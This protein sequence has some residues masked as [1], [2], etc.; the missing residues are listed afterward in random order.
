M[1][2][3]NM[4]FITLLIFVL[5]S[6]NCLNAKPEINTVSGYRTEVLENGLNVFVKE[7]PSAPVVAINVWTHVGSRNEGQGEEGYSH[8]IE[9]LLFKGTKTRGVGD[10]DKEIKKLGATNNAFTATD[11]TCLH[12]FGAK[13]HFEKLLELQIDAAFNSVFDETEFTKELQVVLEELRMDNDD[14]ESR[15]YHETQKSAY[16]NHSYRNPVI[17]YKESLEGATREKVF[18]YY[19]KFYVPGN[20]WIVVVGDVKTEQVIEKVRAL[21]STIAS[22]PIPDQIIKG[23]TPQEKRRES[24][25][26]GDIQQVYLNLAWHAPGISNPDNFAMDVISIMMGRGRSSRLYK[27]LVEVEGLASDLRAVY[28]TS[29]DPSLFYVSA[30]CKPSMKLQL[31]ERVLEMFEELKNDPIIPN[32]SKSSKSKKPVISILDE[33]EKAKQQLIAST[34]FDRETAESQ[35]QNYGQYAILG[36]LEDADAYISQIKKVKFEDVQRVARQYFTDS[37]LN[38]VTYEPASVVKTS[39]PEMITLENG[40]KLVLYPNH[41]SPVVGMT[42]NIDAGGLREGKNEAGVANIT[43]ATLLKGTEAKSADEIASEFESMGTSV[44]CKAQ[45]SLATLKM[46]CISDKFLPSMQILSECLSAPSFPENEVSREKEKSLEALKEQDDDLFYFT[47]F[48]ALEA[49]FPDSPLGYSPLGQTKTLKQIQAEDVKKFYKKYYTGSN[50]VVAIVGDFYTEDIK[51]ILLKIFSEIPSGKS[52]ELKEAKPAVIT[53]PAEIVHQKNREQAQIVVLF[54]TFQR[55][56]PFS[57]P[58]EI[59]KCILSG[60]MYSRLFINLRDRESLAYAVWATQVGATNGGYFFATISTAAGNLE[61]ARS[62]L[63]EELRLFREKG[64]TNEEFEDAK[65][66]LV[67]QY[68]LNLVDFLSLSDAMATDEFFGQGFDYYTKYPEIINDLTVEDVKEAS[69]KYLLPE[70]SYTV[71]ITKP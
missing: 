14:P 11:F 27:T 67:G 53:T 50:M 35:A 7:L 40:L 56:S 13:D 26:T 66:Y 69:E 39:K 4:L 55:N 9:H 3:L 20:M 52:S 54:P 25:I 23:E 1:A 16:K 61:K 28:Y 38:V 57:P 17:G 65:S 29:E 58:M 42:I 68:A 43:A 47:Y 34:I 6:M 22:G 44:S 15:I 12:V 45:K 41:S 71:A 59:I 36:K 62:R 10:I 19:K 24:R 60:S 37:T 32:E 2:S 5:S 48:K 49:V 64:F 21:T 63:I 70:K 31:K 30:Q 51:D 46:K 8:F 33:I 18:N